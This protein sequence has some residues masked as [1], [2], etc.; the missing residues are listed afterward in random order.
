MTAVSSASASYTVLGPDPTVMQAV[1]GGTIQGGSGADTIY[2]DVSDYALPGDL[3][4]GGSGPL[5][6]V[7]LTS[8]AT[9]V[10]GSGPLTVSGA[11]FGTFYGSASGNNSF[12]VSQSTVFGG[13]AGDQFTAADSLV[14]MGAGAETVNY[15]GTGIGMDTVF[16]GTGPDV[17]DVGT[18][19]GNLIVAGSGTET[20]FSG[21]LPDV[22]RGGIGSPSAV[23]LGSGTDKLAVG[24]EATFVQ[25]GT[26]N[27]TVF[28]G[29]E[30]YGSFARGDLFAFTDGTAG[31]TMELHGFRPGEDLISLQGYGSGAVQ[32]ALASASVSG[33]STVL[34]LPD[35][36]RITLFGLASIGGAAFV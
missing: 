36:T 28:A 22:T 8:R 29:A 7:G 1:D 12:D 5:T 25:A 34:T 20:I 21:Q 35:S 9:V 16:G 3:V 19:G 23:F 24:P 27:A 32:A 14:V 17:I 30:R 31:G 15:A 13:G 33:G 6:F 11:S 2:G 18:G 4:Y 26:G 10:G